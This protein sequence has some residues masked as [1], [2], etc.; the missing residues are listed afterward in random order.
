M[1]FKKDDPKINKAGRPKG[2]PNKTT[3]QL[4]GMFQAFLEA[5][6]ETLQADFDK[7]E[8][9]ER[10]SF[11]ERVAKLVMPAPLHELERLTDEQLQELINKLRNEKTTN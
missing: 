1:P 2:V 10:L 3:D 7:L 9:K 6:L 4:R 11:I 5:N 8:P